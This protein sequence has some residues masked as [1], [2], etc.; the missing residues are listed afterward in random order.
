VCSW[1]LCAWAEIQFQADEF[2]QDPSRNLVTAKGRVQIQTPDGWLFADSVLIHTDTEELEGEGHVV[3]Q[4]VG[5]TIEAA[6]ARYNLKKNTGAFEHFYL[7]S[8]DTFVKGKTLTRV[9]LNRYLIEDG[10][11]SPCKGECKDWM[12]SGKKMDLTVQEYVWI[13]SA[14]V[15]VGPMPALYFPV[16]LLPAK[17][18][19]QTG[20]LFPYF[21]IIHKLGPRFSFPFFVNLSPHTDVT[22]TPQWYSSRGIGAQVEHRYRLSETWSGISAL[23]MAYDAERKK[24]HAGLQTSSATYFREPNV[25]ASLNGYVVSSAEYYTEFVRSGAGSGAS[26]LPVSVGAHQGSSWGDVSVRASFIRDVLPRKRLFRDTH[27]YVLPWIMVD[28]TAWKPTSWLSFWVTGSLLRMGHPSGEDLDE[29]PDAAD[30]VFDSKGDVVSAVDKTPGIDDNDIMVGVTEL[31]LTPKMLVSASLFDYLRW[32][33]VG[34]TPYIYYVLPRQSYAT[35]W[36]PQA[37]H[38]FSATFEAGYGEDLDA[39]VIHRVTPAVAQTYR[40]RIF[41]SG[42]TTFFTGPTGGLDLLA[43][44]KSDHFFTF[45]LANALVTKFKD[46]YTTRLTVNVSW[47]LHTDWGVYLEPGQK[48]S[49]LGPVK[50]VSTASF[51]WVTLNFETTSYVDNDWLTDIAGGATVTPWPWLQV[52]NTLNFSG[53]AKSRST[54]GSFGVSLLGLGGTLSTAAD[55]SY[56]FNTGKIQSKKFS[57]DIKPPSHC[58][59]FSLQAEQLLAEKDYTIS[60]NFTLDF[61]SYFGISNPEKHKQILPN[62]GV[63]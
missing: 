12:V 48:I 18:H 13:Y 26:G 25:S 42:R 44:L 3:L 32:R 60:V 9:A 57:F 2:I 30:I 56:S 11:Y 61:G 37:S 27:T 55:L 45:S 21:S 23:D 63:I 10:A 52:R 14:V 62:I 38:E 58:W 1:S 49:L 19:R 6:R 16:L 40:P 4:G 35:L 22:L 39:M 34:L 8:Q 59:S 17:T 15:H 5:L 43:Q 54:Q 50:S 20:F 36:V 24:W 47:S 33:S 53:A 41:R 28:S 46:S 51:D 7:F 31:A 29:V